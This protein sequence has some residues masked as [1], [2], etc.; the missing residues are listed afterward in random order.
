MQDLEYSMW[1]SSIMHKMWGVGVEVEGDIM[2]SPEE[3]LNF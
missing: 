2:E 1:E 3:I